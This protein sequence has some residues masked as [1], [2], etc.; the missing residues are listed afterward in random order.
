M[1]NMSEKESLLQK[2]PYWNQLS[3]LQKKIISANST[4]EFFPQ[5]K[6]IDAN[7]KSCLGMFYIKS[8][9]IRVYISSEEGREITLFNM[10]ENDCCVLAAS[11]AINQ[12]T[13]DAQLIAE[14]ESHIL[15]INAGTFE[16]LA[17]ENIYV[18]CFM[19]E[20]LTEK[21]SSVMRTMQQILFSKIDCRL[22][23]YLLSEYKKNGSPII[24]KTHEQIAVQISSARE[25]V[26]KMLKRFVQEN[27]VELE[28]GKI[29]LKNLEQLE[30]LR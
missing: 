22:A 17:K 21:F 15:I 16:K 29:I 12:I 28:R 14:D 27:L 23:T 25:V 5:G 11:C 10:E 18:K 13:F 2:L 26:A 8:G 19:Y 7:K 20:L 30:K 4:L 1:E 9:K 6:I 3:E 24:A